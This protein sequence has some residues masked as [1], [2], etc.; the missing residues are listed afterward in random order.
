MMGQNFLDIQYIF[1]VIDPNIKIETKSGQE[2][3]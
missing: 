2:R 3:K 1:A